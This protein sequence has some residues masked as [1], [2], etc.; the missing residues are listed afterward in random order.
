VSILW[1]TN[2]GTSC[3]VAWKAESDTLWKDLAGTVTLRRIG[4]ANQ[5]TIRG[6]RAG[7]GYQ[8]RIFTD[9]TELSPET[10]F[11]FHAAFAPETPFS[12]FAAG[13]IGE[14]VADGGKPDRMAQSV[15]KLVDSLQFG[16]LLGDVVYPNGESEGYDTN[17]FNYFGTV[18]SQ[19][20]AYAVLG[21]HEW[22]VDPELNFVQEWK[23]P[24]NEHYYSFDYG[25]TH[26]IALDSKTGD[27]YEYRKQKAWLTKD[28][29]KAKAKKYQ[30]TVVFVHYNGKSCTYKHDTKRL[31]ELYPL[32]ATYGVDLVLNGHAHTYERLTPMN[33]KGDVLTDWVGK[34]E[35]YTDV[36][37]FISITVGSGG[38]LRGIGSDPE[39]YQPDPEHC[40]HPNLV[41]FAS[42]DWAFL[43]V[44][45]TGNTLRAQA[46]RSEDGTMLD[47]FTITK[48]SHP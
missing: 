13:D 45:I 29:Q 2:T 30:W 46:L 16:L 47:H 32:F 28:L 6:L 38:K 17:L 21:N 5:V 7:A 33:G 3:K 37:G 44:N 24:G 14:P 41:A 40:V 27:F 23:L 25:N 11:A 12:F 9:E 36:N 31:I 4:V 1:K 19:I 15:E 39:P 8:Y 26:F 48:T 20:P 35:T 10:P 34:N 18:F 43:R 22:H 42:H